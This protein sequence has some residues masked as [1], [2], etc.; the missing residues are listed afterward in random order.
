[1]PSKR[2]GLILRTLMSHIIGHDVKYKNEMIVIPDSFGCLEF[3]KPKQ[4]I[5]EKILGMRESFFCMYFHTFNTV[6]REN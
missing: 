2:L 4:L 3:A 5:N 1:M 6:L